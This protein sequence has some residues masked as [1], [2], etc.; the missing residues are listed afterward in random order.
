MSTRNLVPRLLRP[1]FL[2]LLL[3][4]LRFLARGLISA[5][6]EI[7]DLMKEF[8]VAN[9]RHVLYWEKLAGCIY[10][11]CHF[12]DKLG[13]TFFTE[14][15]SSTD[16]TF[17]ASLYFPF[18]SSRNYYIGYKYQGGRSINKYKYQYHKYLLA[19]SFN[20]LT[21]NMIRLLLESSW[22]WKL[23]MYIR[24]WR[25]NKQCKEEG[26]GKEVWYIFLE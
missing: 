10:A 19:T 11:N 7:M 21:C 3:C 17:F 6:V 9:C 5:F 20:V 2:P 18:F 25:V 4:K 13:V 12:T 26:E 14:K 8:F 15:F 23:E 16:K 1:I 24:H 22:E